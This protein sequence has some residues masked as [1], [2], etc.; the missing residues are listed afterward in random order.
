MAMQLFRSKLLFC[1]CMGIL[2]GVVISCAT[3]DRK[4]SEASIQREDEDDDPVSRSVSSSRRLVM[5][6]LSRDPFVGYSVNRVKV[7][8]LV[9]RLDPVARSSKASPRILAAYLSAQRLAGRPMP[10]QAA[11]ARSIADTL[12]KKNVDAEVPASIRLELAIS[13]VE[14]GNLA[15]AEFFYDPLLK[16][17]DSRLRA[18]ALNLAGVVAVRMDRVPEAV[19]AFKESL[20]ASDNYAPAKLNLGMLAL[21]GGDFGLARS[22]LSGLGGSGDNGIVSAGLVSVTRFKE[23]SGEAAELCKSETSKHS[24]YKPLLFNCALNA[25]Q[26]S[27]RDIPAARDYLA[28]MLRAP[29]AGKDSDRYSDR[30][31]RLLMAVDSEAASAKG[32]GGQ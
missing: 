13:A 18:A 4:D 16:S 26:G 7:D 2:S 30:A 23:G 6:S 11:T 8:Q 10:D 28:K 22:M 19:E 20:K 32:S 9:T 5:Q 1:L 17:K 15:L 27:S 3:G 21:D 31:Q 14:S 12:M 25:L 24:S 29:G